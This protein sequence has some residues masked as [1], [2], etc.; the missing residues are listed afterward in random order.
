[1]V[2]YEI[3]P[4]KSFILCDK[5]ANIMVSRVIFVKNNKSIKRKN[6]VQCIVCRHWLATD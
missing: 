5:C 4:D 3:K 1:M 2:T 6:I